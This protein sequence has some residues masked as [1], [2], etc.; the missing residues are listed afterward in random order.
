MLTIQPSYNAHT[1]SKRF[2]G[3]SPV[4]L[5]ALDAMPMHNRNHLSVSHDYKY[6]GY[7]FYVLMRGYLNPRLNT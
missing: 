5:T 2:F 4:H 1:R 6:F 3:L 7:A